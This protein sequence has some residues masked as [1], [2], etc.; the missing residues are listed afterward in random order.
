MS[1]LKCNPLNSVYCN[2]KVKLTGSLNEQD[3]G[4]LYSCTLCNDCHMAGFN[5]DAREIAVSKSMVAPHVSMV[6]KNIREHGNPYG[7]AIV[8]KGNG[9]SKNGTILFRGCTATYKTPGMLASVESLLMRKGIEFGYIDEEPCCGNILFNMGDVKSGSEI[10]KDNISRLKA[11]GVKRIITVC[12][13]CYA[14][15]NKYYKGQEGFDVEVL[16]AVDLLEG[17]TFPADGYVVQDPCH[18]KEKAG[19]VR[20]LLTGA[21][22]RSPSPC[23]GSGSGLFIHDRQLAG[24]KAL[25]AVENQSSVITYCPFCF[26]GLSTVKPGSITDIYTLLDRQADVQKA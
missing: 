22:N 9:A 25:K 15:F 8:R 26:V 4:G 6:G 13:G 16:L 24:A 23:C 11:A 10:V 17:M 1:A 7:A 5:R 12:P 20:K 14:A 18:A 3:L 19:A 2:L 21:V